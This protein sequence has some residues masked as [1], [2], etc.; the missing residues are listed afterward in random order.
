DPMP[1]DAGDS[2]ESPAP[3]ARPGRSHGRRR[4]PGARR[5]LRREWRLASRGV[6][7][8][9]VLSRW[10]DEP[11]PSFPDDGEGWNDEMAL[12]VVGVE[13]HSLSD[14]F[15]ARRSTG[16]IHHALD[17]MEPRAPRHT[18]TGHSR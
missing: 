12:P 16:R 15:Y 13:P 9:R 6:I 5:E 11:P 8:P 14:S 17:L 2:L 1:E 4:S 18:P 7:D 10:R 3:P